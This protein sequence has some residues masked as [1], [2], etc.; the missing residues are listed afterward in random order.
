MPEYRAELKETILRDVFIPR[1][2]EFF[3]TTTGSTGSWL[4]DFRAILLQPHHLSKITSLLWESFDA[5]TWQVGGLESAAIPL[6]TGAILTAPEGVSA[7]GFFIRKSRKKDGLL[8]MIEGTIGDAPIILVDDILNSGKSLI[9]QVEILEGLGKKVTAIWTILQYRDTTYYE[10]FHA[11][12]IRVISLFTLNDFADSLSVAN[13]PPPVEN[14]KPDAF[15]ADWFFK[16]DNPSY[17]HVLPKSAPVLDEER[18]Y[19]GADNGT[20]WALN[21]NDGSIAWSYKVRFGSNGKYIFSSPA[22]SK[23]TVFFGAYDGNFYALDKKTGAKKWI[24]M[25]A[26]WIGSSPCVSEKLGLVFVGLEFGFFAK[27]GAIVALDTATGAKRWEQS[28][29]G[30][31]H[32][33]PAYSSRHNTLVCGSNNNTLYAL[34]ATTGAL[35]W[36]FETGGEIKG[37]CA[38]DE[39]RGLVCFGSFDRCVYVLDIRTGTVQHRIETNESV[40][41]SPLIHQGHLYIGSL[42]KR[43]YCINLDT[44]IVDWTFATSGRIFAAPIV[45]NNEILIGSNDGRLYIL[46]LSTGKER[47]SF[48]AIERIVNAAAYNSHTHAVFLPTFANELYKLRRTTSGD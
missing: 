25:E 9:R 46:D 45:V 24:F 17:Q 13:L 7:T 19:F 8:R 44:G 10:Y 27:Q 41:A 40:Y 48:Q 4:F 15:T 26:D 36:Q 47:G 35:R 16:S 5:G 2:K 43:V 20:L 1:G 18:V 11:R 31:V 14:P 37:G 28:V 30:M 3:V 23:D 34:D 22:L 42:D 32:A 12:G 6:I 39:D 38:I 29:P 33:S 21:Q